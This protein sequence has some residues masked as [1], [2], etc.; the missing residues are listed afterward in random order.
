LITVMGFNTFSA[1]L[2]GWC[3]VSTNLFISKSIWPCSNNLGVTIKSD[4]NESSWIIWSNWTKYNKGLHLLDLRKTKRFIHANGIWS[5][6]KTMIWSL[7]NP[8]LF[9]I[10]KSSNTFNCFIDIKSWETKLCVRRHHSFEVFIE[11]EHN[12]FVFIL[13]RSE[14][15][16]TFEAFNAVM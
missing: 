10:N 3:I 9:Y 15:F 4:W 8:F 13:L 12:S 11:S 16:S 6:V 2:D 7:W 14:C 1:S 5:D